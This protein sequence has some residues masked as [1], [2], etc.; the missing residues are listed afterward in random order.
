MR[1]LI[2]GV[3]AVGGYFGAR[4]LAAGRDVTF[5]VRPRRAAQLAETGLVVRSPY[6]DLNIPAPPV[7]TADE[8]RSSFDLILL[9]CKAYDLRAAMDSFAPAV[10]SNTVVLPLLNGMRHL[11]ILEQ[12]FGRGAVLGGYCMISANVDP[13]GHIHHVSEPHSLIYGA[14]HASTDERLG[15]IAEVLSGAGFDARL[16]GEIVQEMWEKWVFIASLAGATCLMRSPIGTILAAGGERFVRELYDECARI[17]AA[18]GFPQRE[19]AHQRSLG[20]LTARGSKLS[21]SMLHDIER[22]APTE[23]DHILGDLLARG[24][25]AADDPSSRLA[26]AYVHVRAYEARRNAG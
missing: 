21:A 15:R 18:N 26:L 17:A 1:I 24:G 20:I 25:V 12:R 22:G 11:D 3:G 19:G 8:L 2:V 4:L 13:H 10:G 7:V 6:G 5:L 16:S 9:S 23:G 14:L